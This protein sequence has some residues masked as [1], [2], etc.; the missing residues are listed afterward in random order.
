MGHETMFYWEGMTKGDVEAAPNY[1]NTRS[2]YWV[3]FDGDEYDYETEK[4]FRLDALNRISACDPLERPSD[5]SDDFGMGF[6]SWIAPHDVIDIVGNIQRAVRERDPRAIP[7]MLRYAGTSVTDGSD[8][9]FGIDVRHWDT[10]EAILEAVVDMME[11][12]KERGAKLVTIDGGAKGWAYENAA[13][14]A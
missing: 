1:M 6:N 2:V 5:S 12:A 11:F 10:F 3:L 4:Q 8:F 13:R 7:I 14:L 9:V